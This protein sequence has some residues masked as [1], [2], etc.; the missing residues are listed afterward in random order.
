VIGNRKEMIE[1]LR[2]YDV[3]MALTGRP[4]ID[5]GVESAAFGRHPYV[6]IA[7]ARHPLTRRRRI[8][9]AELAGQ[10]FLVREDGSGTRNI[11]EYFFNEAGIRHPKN[12]IEI[13]SDESIKQAV[14]AGLGISLISAHTIAP[15]VAD[16]RLA[17][18][19]VQ[20]MPIVRQWFVVR[21]SD[22]ELPPAGRA[23]WT[24]IVKKGSAF[25]PGHGSR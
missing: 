16:G 10:K 1:S 25:L 3:D 13:G 4:P 2:N 18:L 22:R 24:F 23:L 20:G 14:M 11:F 15:E 9:K 5:F 19:K 7:A 12:S 21:R 6:I 17:I 8:S